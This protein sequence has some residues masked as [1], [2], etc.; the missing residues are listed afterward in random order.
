MSEVIGKITG[1]HGVRGDVVFEHQLSG[2]INTDS[3]DALMIELLP[4]SYI[5]FFI[6]N[7]KKQSDTS[8]LVKFEEINSPEDASEIL[9]KNVLLS[10]NAQAASVEIKTPA[11]DYIGYTLFDRET[12]IGNIDNILNPNTNPLFIIN[13]G[14]ENE[15]LIPAN[16][17]LILKVDKGAKNIWLEIP[18]G[19]L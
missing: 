12:E 6:A 4:K 5:P 15:L 19:L 7:L 10:P 14:K 17:E 18:E 16:K 13:D 3:W 2:K 11:D 8:F 9:Q 1:S